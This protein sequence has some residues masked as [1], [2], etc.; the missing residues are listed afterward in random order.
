MEVLKH[1]IY[2]QCRCEM[3]SGVRY[4]PKTRHYDIIWAHHYPQFYKISPPPAWHKYVIMN[5]YAHPQHINMLQHFIYFQYECGMQSG[6]VICLIHDLTASLRLSHGTNFPKFALHLH[7]KPRNDEPIC[8]SA[9][10]QGAQTPR[11]H[12]MWM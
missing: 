3:Q 12:P 7:G 5:P 9:S 4:S 8:P 10:Y 2:I 6:V 1:F 11:I